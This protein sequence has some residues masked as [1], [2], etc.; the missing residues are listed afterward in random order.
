MSS[1]FDEFIINLCDGFDKNSID[2]AV[3]RN[4]QTL[5]LSPG[6]SD[7]DILIPTGDRATCLILVRDIIERSGVFLM[8]VANS[9]SFSK[10]FVMGKSSSVDKDWWG[11]CLDINFG[12]HYCGVR[13]VD[14]A[15][16]MP[17][18]DHLGI[19][20]IQDGPAGILGLLKELLNNES[21]V[22]KYINDS[23]SYISSK[24]SELSSML[25]PMGQE[26]ITLLKELLVKDVA[27][28]NVKALN[29]KHMFLKK[30][31]WQ[32]PLVYVY[33]QGINYVN[34]IQRYLK[35]SGKVIAFLGVD[36]A[37]KS[38]VINIIKPPLEMA[39]HNNVFVKHLRPTILPPLAFYRVNFNKH[40]DEKSNTFEQPHLAPSSGNIVSLIRLVYLLIDYIVGYWFSIRKKIAQQP[41]VIIYDRYAYD[42]GLDAKRFR[43][44]LKLNFI[45]FF[46]NFVPKPDLTICLYGDPIV[47]Y[48]RKKE[49]SFDEV[50]RQTESIKAFA[51]ERKNTFMVNTSELDIAQVRDIVLTQIVN[52]YHD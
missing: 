6:G 12:L 48:E 40:Q 15:F 35:P 20:V 23:R 50:V 24:D 37:G 45:N 3:M 39:T 10:I 52:I 41:S 8:G 26:C 46:I 9:Y 1:C 21:L 11:V 7:I 49:L 22:E 4:Y 13:Y 43:I 27:D 34:K 38:S 32:S 25:S 2:Y 47:I 14:Q 5:P 18:K 42:I 17:I 30:C 19:K 36:G 33:K 16:Q 29:F 51:H 44:S 31:F 28:V